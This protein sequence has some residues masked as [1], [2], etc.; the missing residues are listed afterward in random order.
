MP[1]VVGYIK[2]ASSQS[3]A[4]GYT[5]E[6]LPNVS[7]SISVY[8]S[9]GTQGV[10]TG[11]NDADGAFTVELD[12]GQGESYA[13]GPGRP[14]FRLDASRSSS[15]YGNSD[16]VTPETAIVLFGVYAFGE[17]TNVGALD[18]ETLATGL[19][20]VE[21]NLA[22]KLE[23]STV[24]IVE[25][26]SSDTSWYRKWSDGWIEQGGTILGAS[27]KNTVTFP[28]GFRDTN[29]YIQKT[30]HWSAISTA[31][32][33][34]QYFGFHERTTTTATTYSYTVPSD[35]REDWYACGY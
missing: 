4:G 29:Y 14:R 22:S 26:W 32:I 23:T 10:G 30:L 11:Q 34:R 28:V 20:T 2:G 17:I 31:V 18:A 1:K 13:A 35:Y 5:A 21:V 3:E 9:H 19:A 12:S 16:H 7:G 24:H 33:E 27:G 15:I 6:G 25:T 8:T